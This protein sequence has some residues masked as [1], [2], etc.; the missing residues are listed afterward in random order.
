MPDERGPGGVVSMSMESVS[1]NL[2]AVDAHFHSEGTEDVE[3]ALALYTDDIWWES[4]GDPRL[5]TH[6][7]KSA[8]AD[9]YRSMWACMKDVE[10]QNR[11]RFGVDDKVVDESVL[12]CRIAKDGLVP[13]PI[14][15]RVRFDLLHVFDLREG[16]ISRELVYL[17]WTPV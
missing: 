13:V 12:T 4:H 16:K 10:F 2:K 11:R 5:G 17:G 8:V 15:Q 7:G 9:R 1:E 6:R 14:G 3:R